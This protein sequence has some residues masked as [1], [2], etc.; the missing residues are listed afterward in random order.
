MATLTIAF[1]RGLPVVFKGVS[2]ESAFRLMGDYRRKREVASMTVEG[3]TKVPVTHERGLFDFD[4]P[5]RGLAALS[6]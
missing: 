2:S 3:F 1:Y 4:V 6:L 5:I